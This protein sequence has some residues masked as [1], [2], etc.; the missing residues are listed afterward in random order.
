ML[1]WLYRNTSEPLDFSTN[2]EHFGTLVSWKQ[3][4]IAVL[5]IEKIDETAPSSFDIQKLVALV[6]G[7]QPR[8]DDDAELSG[9]ESATF[10]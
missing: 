1:L 4:V 3:A 10:V 8:D 7:R 9:S 2:S 6:R 5:N